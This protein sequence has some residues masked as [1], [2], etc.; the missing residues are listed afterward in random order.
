MEKGS[1][2]GVAMNGWNTN[3]WRYGKQGAGEGKRGVG[4][5]NVHNHP[6]AP[7]GARHA[8]PCGCMHVKPRRETTMDPVPKQFRPEEASFDHV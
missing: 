3:V 5:Y 1:K 2:G 6:H 4:V 8:A 7:Q